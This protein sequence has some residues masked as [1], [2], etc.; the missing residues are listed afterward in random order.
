VVG[1]LV[2]QQDVRLGPQRGADLPAFA[3]SGRESVPALEVSEV[4]AEATVETLRRAVPG[5]GKGSHLTAEIFDPL[6]TDLDPRRRRLQAQLPAS[7][8]ELTDE[9]TQQRGLAAAVG[10]DQTGPAGSQMKGGVREE[11]DAV[12]IGEREV[13]QV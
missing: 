2:E 3:L 10:A 9:Q 13:L 11:R 6:G 4:E 7:R 1:G 8:L 5:L 12:G